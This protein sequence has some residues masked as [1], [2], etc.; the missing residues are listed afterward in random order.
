[1][2]SSVVDDGGDD[3]DD[4]VNNGNDINYN[5]SSYFLFSKY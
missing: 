3:D 1:M 5:L 2:Y 4:V